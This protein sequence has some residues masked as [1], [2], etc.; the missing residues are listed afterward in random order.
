MKELEAKGYKFSMQG[1]NGD[2]QAIRINGTTPEPMSDPRGRHGAVRRTR[3]PVNGR[4]V[5]PDA[6]SRQER[7]QV[8]PTWRHPHSAPPTAPFSFSLSRTIRMARH[9]RHLFRLR[10]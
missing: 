9:D 8:S 4:S 10:D 6:S 7:G 3:D 1:M 5:N 2:I